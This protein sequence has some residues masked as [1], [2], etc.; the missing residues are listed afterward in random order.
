MYPSRLSVKPFA[1]DPVSVSEQVPALPQTL[2][3]PEET[4]RDTTDIS[5]D[6]RQDGP[7]KQQFLQSRSRS[8]KSDGAGTLDLSTPRSK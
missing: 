5:A 3:T 4:C 6:I 2:R 1:L 7:M 8:V